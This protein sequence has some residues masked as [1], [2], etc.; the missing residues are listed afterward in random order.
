[1]AHFS[2]VGPYEGK[3]GEEDV[4]LK[5]TAYR[6]IADH[7]RTLSFAIADGAIPNNEGRG[8][9]LRRI[10]RRATRYGQQILKAP[11]GF[12]QQ[13]I[14]SVIDTFGEA[15]PELVENKATITEVIAEEEEAF[16]NMLD[17]G[18]KFFTELEAD[19]KEAGGKKV[20]GDKAFYLYDT[21]GFPIDLTELMAEEAGLN[22]DTKGFAQEM[23]A[24]K[25]IWTP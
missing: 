16:S 25:Q 17:R 20:T 12:F 14:P 6:A 3:L 5:D 7:I 15:Y 23:E 13:L 18:I 24:Q 8:Y 9:V 4:T 21:L 22:V 1:M 2:E 11:P 10:L 19:V